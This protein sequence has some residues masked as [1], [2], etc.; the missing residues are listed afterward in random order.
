MKPMSAP[1][2]HHPELSLIEDYVAGVCSESAALVVATHLE[3]CP[4]CALHYQHCLQKAGD[5]LCNVLPEKISPVAESVYSQAPFK[6][7][8]QQENHYKVDGVDDILLPQTIQHYCKDTPKWRSVGKN[9]KIGKI[10]K[11][12]NSSCNLFYLKQGASLPTH[13]HYGREYLM[14]LFGSLADENNMYQPGDMVVSDHTITHTPY[15]LSNCLCIAATD[16][17][18]Q[19]TGKRGRMMNLLGINRL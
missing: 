15:A 13:T 6:E 8:D 5:A 7:T 4:S 17:P 18:I 16:G 12:A 14:V 3:Y 2:N 19:F 10:L 11:G 9:L 1:L